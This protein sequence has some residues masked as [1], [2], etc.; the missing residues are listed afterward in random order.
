MAKRLYPF[1]ADNNPYSY[2]PLCGFDAL[3]RGNDSLALEWPAL[4][5]Q[6]DSHE[7]PIPPAKKWCI[8]VTHFP[9]SALKSAI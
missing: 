6:R 3:S 9:I 4:V 5:Y 2:R 7:T 1:A 8:S